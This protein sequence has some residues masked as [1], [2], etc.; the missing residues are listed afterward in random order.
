MQLA[1]TETDVQQGYIL[2]YSMSI[3]VYDLPQYTLALGIQQRPQQYSLGSVLYERIVSDSRV[4]KNPFEASLLFVPLD[5][6]AVRDVDAPFDTCR[7]IDEVRRVVVEPLRE[8]IALFQTKEWMRLEG[9]VVD[10]YSLPVRFRGGRFGRTRGENSSTVESLEALQ[11]ATRHYRALMDN[12]TNHVVPIPRVSISLKRE[13]GDKCRSVYDWLY[14][15]QWITI[16]APYQMKKSEAH[17]LSSIHHT[18]PYP[19]GVRLNNAHDLELIR[20]FQRESPRP[21]LVAQVIGKHNRRGSTLRA[22]LIK[23]C[24]SRVLCTQDWQAARKVAR[25]G[26]AN[27]FVSHLAY[28][29]PH[30]PLY[31]TATFCMQPFGMTPSRNAV[32]QCLLG[33][34]IPVLFE[35]YLVQALAPLFGDNDWA[36]VLKALPSSKNV[37]GEVYDNLVAIPR[38]R[39]DRM[40]SVIANATPRLQYSRTENITDDAY[41]YAFRSVFQTVYRRLFEKN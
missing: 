36:V 13:W 18:V 27:S 6:E 25:D 16:E 38:D 3:F 17:L 4:V 20:E 14:R 30:L 2:V 7:R 23:E 5:L 39:L 31:A 34:G 41:N 40:R 1:I 11:I 35:P 8:K 10:E 12:Y 33:G 15:M 37:L 9:I 21:F 24:S 32:Y 28:V 19:T 22:A 26:A 29:A